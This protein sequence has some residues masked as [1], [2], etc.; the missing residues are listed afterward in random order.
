M[1]M[2]DNETPVCFYPAVLPTVNPPHHF[3]LE[4]NVLKKN[5][6]TGL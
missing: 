5:K 2:G 3:V 1:V 6:V 4:K